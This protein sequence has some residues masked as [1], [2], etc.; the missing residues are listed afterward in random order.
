MGNSQCLYCP[1]ASTF[2]WTT[3]LKWILNGFQP[4]QYDHMRVK[5]KEKKKSTLDALTLTTK[6]CFDLIVLKWLVFLEF[7]SW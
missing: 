7:P 3:R 4:C 1:M 2:S 6:L 5:R